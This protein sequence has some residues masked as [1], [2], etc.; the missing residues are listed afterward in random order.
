MLPPSLTAFNPFQKR[1]VIYATHVFDGLSS[2]WA[3]HLL[4][5]T[6]PRSRDSGGGSNNQSNPN[7]EV[8]AAAAGAAAPLLTS[9]GRLVTVA[10][11]LNGDPAAK[12]S[13]TKQ[14]SIYSV[15][16]KWLNEENRAARRV[17]AQQAT[18]VGNGGGESEPAPA[19]FHSFSTEPQ[20]PTTAPLRRVKQDERLSARSTA[21]ARETGDLPDGWGYRANSL[22]GCVV[23]TQLKNTHN[24]VCHFLSPPLTRGF[25]IAVFS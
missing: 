19:S 11:A 23:H 21:V 25:S 9:S 14:P 2:S 10:D 3:S 16:L 5:L 12:K 24:L 6:K 4:H 17:L 20:F 1:Q 18:I 15:V 22:P 8:A 7:T 13:A